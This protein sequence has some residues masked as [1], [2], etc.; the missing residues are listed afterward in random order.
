MNL[1]ELCN[2]NV[3]SVSNEDTVNYACKLFR[4]EH[5]GCLV[6]TD[7]YEGDSQPIGIITD[8]D[9]VVKVIALGTSIGDVLVKDV[10][11]S[12]F[13]TA[14]INDDLGMIIFDSKKIFLFLNC[15]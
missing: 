11:D 7:L 13:I 15:I 12:K 1:S 4:N 9:I 10:M 2:K 8:R 3:V 5:V 6:V 14:N